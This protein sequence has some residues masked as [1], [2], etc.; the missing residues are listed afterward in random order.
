MICW[1]PL[2]Q[3]LQLLA[4]QTIPCLMAY[5]GVCYHGMYPNGH[6]DGLT[7]LVLK[8]FPL[9][10]RS[11]LHQSDSLCVYLICWQPVTPPPFQLNPPNFK[12]YIVLSSLKWLSN[13]LKGKSIG[14]GSLL[15]SSMFST[16]FCYQ[17]L[18]IQ[19]RIEL[20]SFTRLF[21]SHHEKHCLSMHQDWWSAQ[22]M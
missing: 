5:D 16:V 20:R 4:F 2:H 11:Q 12:A 7:C 10:V 14:T 18:I 19:L 17:I 15:P 13:V 9:L 1:I 21:Q 22:W 3:L 8:L 6:L